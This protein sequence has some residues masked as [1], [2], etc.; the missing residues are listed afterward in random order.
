[1]LQ[2]TVSDHCHIKKV[3]ILPTIVSRRFL[4]RQPIKIAAIAPIN[5]ALVWFSIILSPVGINT[6][7]ITYSLDTYEDNLSSISVHSCC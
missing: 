3:S 4:V 7:G 6:A 5:L 2:N 1:M